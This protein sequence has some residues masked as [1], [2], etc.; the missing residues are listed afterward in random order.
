MQVITDKNVVFTATLAGANKDNYTIK[1]IPNGSGKI[2]KRTIKIAIIN[3]VPAATK[4]KADTKTGSATATIPTNTEY[5]DAADTPH[6]VVDGETVAITYEYSYANISSVG[7][8][9]D[10]TVSNIATTN[11]NYTVEPTYF[12]KS[13]RYSEQQ[14]YKIYRYK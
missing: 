7:P 3:N 8:V 9:S 13:K 1:A 6:Q 12:G 14:N 2:N 10:V 11:T 5:E 4:N